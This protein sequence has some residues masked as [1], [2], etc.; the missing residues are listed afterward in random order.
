MSRQ[1]DYRCKLPKNDGEHRLSM[2]VECKNLGPDTRLVVCGV[3]RRRSEAFH[4]L[5]VSRC[6]QQQI[7]S[8]ESKQAKTQDALYQYGKFVGK[9]V[10]V[11][12]FSGNSPELKGDGEIYQRW[13]QAVDSAVDLVKEATVAANRNKPGEVHS[14]ILPILVVPDESLWTTHFDSAGEISSDPVNALECTYFIG[15]RIIAPTPHSYMVGFVFS[16]VH[17]FTLTGFKSF[18]NKMAMNDHAWDEIF[19]A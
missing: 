11:A 9:S 19:P 12:D 10:H 5:V 18:L 2:A 16:H 4:T 1:Y 8:F 6:N 14:A 7:D 15:K 13:T 3:G 17:I